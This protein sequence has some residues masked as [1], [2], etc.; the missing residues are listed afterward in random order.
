MTNRN[1]ARSRKPIVKTAAA[2]LMGT[3]LIFSAAAPF[4]FAAD[5]ASAGDMPTAKPIAVV[6]SATPI[7]DAAH[8]TFR[9]VQQTTDQ[10]ETDLQIPVI[11]GM[12][13]TAYQNTLNANLAARVQAAADAISKQ[14]KDD[15]A[16]ND[17]SYPFRAYGITVRSEL[18]SDG[19]AAARGVLSFRVY[20]YTY[21]GGA[22]GST[23][24]TTYNI[25][26]SEQA[27]PLKLKDF[28]GADY[29][30]VINK[31]VKAEIA[32]R[33]D[34]FFLDTPF[35]TIA[36]DQA[37]YI[38]NGVAYIIFQQYEIAPYAAG[39]PE[40]A[41]AVPNFL[42]SF[43]ANANKLPLM[44]GGKS[45]EGA[46]LYV[47][48]GG[49]AMVPLRPIAAALGF[50]ITYVASSHKTFLTGFGQSSF[51]VTGKNRYAAGENAS[52]SLGAAPASISGTLYVPADFF[53]TVLGVGVAYT[54]QAITF[55]K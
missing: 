30:T 21:T 37:F 22:H 23:I 13:D 14:A 18:L 50:K 54:K 1:H 42:A 44:A 16:A 5:A 19:S 7:S 45:V 41:I 4:A 26:N 47:A 43:P 9:S 31:A 20:T 48:S 3:A 36:D 24:V 53:T 32:K 8:L 33:P 28:F 11:T 40:F 38:R 6:S 49:Q 51:I 12:K 27:S 17:S 10:L 52:F 29:K 35:R 55:G 2:A 34:D 39:M 46:H 25:R 15:Y